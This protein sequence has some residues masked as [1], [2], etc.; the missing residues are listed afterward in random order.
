MTIQ[1]PD[2]ILEIFYRT[3][4]SLIKEMRDSDHNSNNLNPYHMEGDVWTHTMAVFTYA[5]SQNFP[6]EVQIAALLHDVGKPASKEFKYSGSRGQY[7][8]FTG[9]EGLSFYMCI[10]ILE[11]YQLS[12]EQKHIILELVASHSHLYNLNKKESIEQMYRGRD[13]FYE[14]LTQLVEADTLGR[15]STAETRNKS[16]KHLRELKDIIVDDYESVSHKGTLTLM[17]G[18]PCSGK[19]TLVGELG[20]KCISRDSCVMSLGASVNYNDNWNKVDQKEVDKLFLEQVNTTL[21]EGIDV[22]IDKTHMSKKS[23]KQIIDLAR[24][25]NY[26]IKVIIVLTSLRTIFER[27]ENRKDKHIKPD[28]ILNMIKSF[29]FPT[30]HECDEINF[31]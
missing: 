17:I 28:I 22:V 19:S 29:Y 3:Q 1:T 7:C 18:P 12:K 23:R 13:D 4:G 10:D 26:K 16:E 27:N 11:H 15:I 9:H 6:M 8:R 20:I 2:E 25:S 24:K 31:C 21:K 30:L 14:M 5:V